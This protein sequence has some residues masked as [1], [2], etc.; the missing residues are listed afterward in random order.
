[1][2]RSTSLSLAEAAPDGTEAA[3][4]DL[5]VVH[6]V[7]HG[8]REMFE[9]IVRR[10]N[11]R[12]YRVGMAYLRGHAQTEDAMQNAY[13]KAYLQL[14]RFRGTSSFGTWLTRIMINE[15]LMIL[16]SSRR[17]PTESLEEAGAGVEYAAFVA[18]P[19]P[20]PI[21]TADMRSLLEQAL[22]SLPR[23]HRAVY[24]LREVQ[25]L[26]TA[27]TAQCLGLSTTNVKV[28][29]HRA[30]EALK[31]ELLRTAA[32]AELFS[33]PARYCD[34]LTHRVM[35]AVR[36]SGQQPQVAGRP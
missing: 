19:A 5:G 3:P 20:D 32:V 8:N 26:S 12:L 18:P 9:V 2:S 22:Q 16:R 35:Q 24:L 27:E 13:V 33:Y 17:K 31:T 6:E 1:M 4:T 21:S 28:C 14:G 29:L 11:A 10:Y 23:V 36:T 7:I 34:P 30:R 15:C 25:H